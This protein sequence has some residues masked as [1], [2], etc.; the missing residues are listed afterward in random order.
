MKIGVVGPFNPHILKDYLVEDSDKIPNIN[1][2]ATSVNLYVLGLMNTG[3]E[4]EVFTTDNINGKE[5]VLQGDGI[6]IH[7]IS[8]RTRIKG[9]RKIRC[10]KNIY[11]S[12]KKEINNLDIIH[13]EWTYEYAYAVR[14][15]KGKKPIF[16]SVR[17]WCPYLIKLAKTIE[18]K[19][20]WGMCYFMFNKVMRTKQFT[21]I[22]NSN[23]ICNQITRR[24]P[25]RSV[26]IIPNPFFSKKIL[27]TKGKKTGQLN[28][29]SIAQSL[30]DPRK[31]IE[32]LLV[33][34]HKYLVTNNNSK[35]I[36]VG[37]YSREWKNQMEQKNLLD[38]VV[39][40]G[41]IKYDDVF[42]FP[43]ETY[44]V[45][46]N[47]KF[48]YFFMNTVVSR[49]FVY[50]AALAAFLRYIYFSGSFRYCRRRSCAEA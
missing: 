41:V 2:A 16:C 4:V 3:N 36:L 6:K 35:L 33:A 43:N 1:N 28:F 18:E 30:I 49:A 13:A 11:R 24:Y 38:N 7:I 19:Y 48:N 10:S 8:N 20:Y 50:R 46:K 22:A 32:V 29:I 5:Y 25:N 34:F 44:K 9:F 39:L 40:L 31:N 12:I 26:A 45:K 27:T 37:Y 21:F 47:G 14:R 15:F 17:D 23:Y 42:V